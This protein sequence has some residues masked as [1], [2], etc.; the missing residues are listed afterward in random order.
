MKNEFP[1]SDL[2]ANTSELL[3]FLEIELKG[4]PF[5][6]YL[7]C[8]HS[9][10]FGFDFS[11]SILASNSNDFK[12]TLMEQHLIN[13]YDSLWIQTGSCYLWKFLMTKKHDF[14]D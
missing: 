2:Q 11:F 1:F 12:V 6:S 8:G 10:D 3:F 7:F 14:I 5:N 13:R 9:F 4:I